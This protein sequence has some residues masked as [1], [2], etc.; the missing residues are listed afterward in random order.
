MDTKTKIKDICDEISLAAESMSDDGAAVEIQNQLDALINKLGF[1]TSRLMLIGNCVEE[2]I[3]D[4]LIEDAEYCDKH[5]INFMGKEC[6]DCEQEEAQ[7]I[8]EGTDNV[9]V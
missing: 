5:E 6:Y 2:Q 4:Y 7:A 1:Y 9:T 3:M 8:A